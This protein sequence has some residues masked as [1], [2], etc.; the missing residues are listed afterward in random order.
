MKHLSKNLVRYK[1]EVLHYPRV[2]INLGRIMFIIARKRAHF[3]TEFVAEWCFVLH[4]RVI[5]TNNFLFCGRGGVHKA[6][7]DTIQ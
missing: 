2:V 3:T 7:Q 5:K 6:G 4:F 1:L